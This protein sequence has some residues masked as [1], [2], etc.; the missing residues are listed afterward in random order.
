MEAQRLNDPGNDSIA[1]VARKRRWTREDAEALCEAQQR[2][3]LTL[4]R[5]AEIHGIVAQR[6]RRWRDQSEHNASGPSSMTPDV[7]FTP[8][9]LVQQQPRKRPTS[10]VP[11]PPHPA[12]ASNF[13]P[14]ANGL[15]VVLANGRCVRV[16][17]DFDAA[18]VVRLLAIVEG[19]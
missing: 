16:P 11:Y 2:S 17:P 15:E 14:E 10:E 9:R 1:V 7:K 13:P 12:H 3:G 19:L 6:L 18:S 5:F 4:E 8:V